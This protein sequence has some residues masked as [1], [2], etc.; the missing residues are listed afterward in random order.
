MEAR[1]V[2][3][4]T[5][6]YGKCK[7]PAAAARHQS[8]LRRSSCQAPAVPTPTHPAVSGCS[9][10]PPSSRPDNAPPPSPQTPARHGSAPDFGQ[11]GCLGS[12][13]PPPCTH[14]P[15]PAGRARPGSRASRSTADTLRHLLHVRRR[16][17]A[18]RH[19]PALHRAA[20]RNELTTIAR[21]ANPKPPI[22]SATTL[23]DAFPWPVGQVPRFMRP[24]EPRPTDQPPLQP[25]ERSTSG[26]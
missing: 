23:D 8:P 25:A 22:T 17:P 16:H 14:K 26:V 4:L 11:S 10:P 7:P 24:G 1:R 15:T 3:R 19:R 9:A 20:S 5:S 12:V 6:L 18:F 13:F 21:T 2:P